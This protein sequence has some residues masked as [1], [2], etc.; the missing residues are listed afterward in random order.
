MGMCEYRGREEKPLY[1]HNPVRVSRVWRVIR[2]LGDITVQ[3]NHM[4]LVL[5]F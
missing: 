4:V 5:T 1:S 3:P 2:E